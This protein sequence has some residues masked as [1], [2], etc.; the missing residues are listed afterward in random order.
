MPK[1]YEPADAIA[2]W[3]VRPA[4]SRSDTTTPVAASG[5]LLAT[6][7]VNV[8]LVPTEGLGL[9]TVFVTARSAAGASTDALAESSAELGSWVAVVAVAVLVIGAVPATCA[10]TDSV[11]DAPLA[12]VP[13]VQ[14]PPE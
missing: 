5:P 12:S 14:T 11:A 13:T 3:K 2:D 7:T 1:L 10:W 8:T 4:G 9:S 6:V